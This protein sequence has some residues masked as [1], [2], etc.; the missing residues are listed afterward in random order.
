MN[1]VLEERTMAG[2][3]IQTS[4]RIGIQIKDLSFEQT[5]EPAAGTDSVAAS[6]A[7]GF[8]LDLDHFVSL[9][10]QKY[11]YHFGH[12]CYEPAPLP[13][14]PIPVEPDLPDGSPNP[15]N[16]PPTVPPFAMDDDSVSFSVSGD[17]FSASV[18]SSVSF[19]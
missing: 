2:P 7:G 10:K 17:G 3:G 4:V 9:F 6:V 5:L 18:S 15:G 16:F 8:H 11:G 14:G 1:R 19:H 12:G 13:S